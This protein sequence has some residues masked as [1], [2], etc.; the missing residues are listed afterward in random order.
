MLATRLAALARAKAG[1]VS[2]LVGLV[3]L[4][5]LPAAQTPPH[6]QDPTPRTLE[7][8]RATVERVLHETGVPGAGLG[9]VR[10]SEIEWVGGLGFADRD[11]KTPVTADTH[12]RAGSVSK[13]FVAMALVQMSGE[14]LVD[15]DAPLK[16]VAPEVAIEN[17]WEATEAVRVID[18]LQHTA[19]F[20]DM[21]FNEMYNVADP[22]DLPLA[23]VLARNPRSRRSRW[24]PGTRMSYSNP[25]YG[26]AG[27]L[28]EKL[29][30]EP[31]EDYIARH[32]FAPLG[33]TTSSF[34]LRPEDE[35]MLARG[36]AG[37]SGP[38]VPFTPIYLRPAGNLHTSPRE[39][40]EFVQ[41]LLGW[42]EFGDAF[43]IDP[44]YLGNMERPRRTLASVAGLRNGYGSGIAHMLTFPY[45]MLGH[46]GGID[47]FISSYAYSPARDA[48][49]VVLLNSAASG[50]AMSRISSLAVRYLKRE[51]E[52]PPKP[53]ADVDIEALGR[54]E[55]YYHDASPRNQILAFIEWLTSGRTIVLEGNT[56][57]SEPVFGRRVPLVP[58]SDT[59]FRLE[60]E[61]DASR[62][63]TTDASGKA[64]L[65]GMSIYAE[66]R[67]RWHVEIVRVPVLLSVLVILTPLA[68]LVAWLA[69]AR[70]ARPRG[71]WELKMLMT[72]VPIAIIA[73]VTALAITPRRYWG[74]FNLATALAFVGPLT[75][76]A[77]ALAVVALATAAVRESAGRWLVTYALVVAA[78]TAGIAIYLAYW[79]VLGIR[80]WNY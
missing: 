48:G 50:A 52:P 34:R 71:F 31:Y 20:D 1:V 27:Y 40:A 61:V 5:G 74:T 75:L 11:A 10:R 78:A 60:N 79:G 29:A 43:V 32:I 63:F 55:G 33:M 73:P 7:E 64:V 42:G 59:L 49:F 80:L 66:R 54:H 69:R 70:R 36:Y 6:D 8:F 41:M 76:P 19:G 9:L 2:S 39:L 14:G 38:P 56:L 26:V 67:P 77:L 12:F 46:G 37:R 51:V 53:C 3:A 68:A 13:T 72:L 22:P 25:G 30:G 65:T 18:L 44:E 24:Q 28:V 15:L 16:E 57:F 21:H 35:P 4:A 23:E 45:R 17:P 62:V 47:G 58:L